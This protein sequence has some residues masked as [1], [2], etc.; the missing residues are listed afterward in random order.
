MKNQ[1]KRISSHAQWYAAILM[2]FQSKKNIV[3][4]K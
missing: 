4:Q 3:L 2:Y 1:I